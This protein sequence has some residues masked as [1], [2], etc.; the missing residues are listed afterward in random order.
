MDKGTW[1]ATVHRIAKSRT[2]LSDSHT[3]MLQ[4]WEKGA[5]PSWET[6]EAPPGFSSSVSPTEQKAFNTGQRAT[7]PIT[8][9]AW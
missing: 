1:R 9:R 4:A 6:H 2:R 3:D 8:L 7:R 5:Q